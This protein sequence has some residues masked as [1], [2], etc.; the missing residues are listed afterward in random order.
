M[1]RVLRNLTRELSEN[2]LNHDLTSSETQPLGF[3]F[4]KL[5]KILEQ[6]GLQR[7]S[8]PDVIGKLGRDLRVIPLVN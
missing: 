2:Q 4:F 5:C 3:R 7:V 1:L 8:I 6:P